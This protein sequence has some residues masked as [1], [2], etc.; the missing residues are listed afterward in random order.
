M[1]SAEVFALRSVSLSVCSGEY[2]AITG[3]SGSGK[4]TLLHIIGCLDSPTVGRYSLDSTRVEDLS[5]DELSTIRNRM[6]GFVFQSFHLMPQLNVV[7]NVEIPLLYRRIER[8][9]RKALVADV[10][11]KVGLIERRSHRSHELSGGE[12]QRVAIARALV[13]S[14]GILLADEPTG[15]LDQK[16]GNE[17]MDLLESL[18]RE[19]ATMLLVTHDLENARRAGRLD[20]MRD[21]R[22]IR[23]SL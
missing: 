21:G 2:V 5:D 14:P 3:P 17:I 20:E 16:T 22:L 19:G 8:R 6:M 23:S 11:E 12:R 1:G 15:N 10:L 13:G 18:N 9:R 7:E 4:S